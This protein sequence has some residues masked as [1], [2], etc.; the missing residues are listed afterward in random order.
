MVKS[1]NIIIYIFCLTFLIHTLLFSQERRASWQRQSA[2]Q[3]PDL[4]LFHSL[5]V[6]NLP[7]AETLQKG[8]FA[9]PASC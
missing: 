3:Q 7:T 8:D 4:Q 1:K 9:E 5:H 6:A 2:P